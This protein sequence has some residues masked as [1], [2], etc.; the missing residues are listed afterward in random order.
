M[1]LFLSSAFVVPWDEQGRSRERG[2]RERGYAREY[3]RGNYACSIHKERIFLLFL[4]SFSSPPLLNNSIRVYS[5]TWIIWF[6]GSHCCCLN[7]RIVRAKGKRG[8]IERFLIILILLF[9]GEIFNRFRSLIR[10]NWKIG[11]IEKTFGRRECHSRSRNFVEIV[12]S[13]VLTAPRVNQ[14]QMSRTATKCEFLWFFFEREK[15]FA[16]SK[17]S[18]PLSLFITNDFLFLSFPIFARSLRLHVYLYNSCVNSLH[19]LRAFLSR[20]GEENE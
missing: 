11:E 7:T 17:I 12:R 13:P 14:G 20:G 10:E 8:G 1:R 3:F 5:C 15:K 6:P 4:S 2:E 16:R 19:F 9:F 18:E